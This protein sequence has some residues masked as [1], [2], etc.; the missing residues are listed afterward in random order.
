MKRRDEK[1]TQRARKFAGAWLL[2]G[3]LIAYPLLVAVLYTE[4]LDWMASW[5]TLVFFIIAGLFWA[6]PAGMIIKWMAKPDERENSS[7]R[8]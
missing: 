5:A 8:D 2:I 6:V 3:W 1:V 4:L 7:S